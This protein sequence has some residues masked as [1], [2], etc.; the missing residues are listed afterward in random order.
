MKIA[1]ISSI[2][3]TRDMKHLQFDTSHH[4]KSNE[5]IILSVYF[6]GLYVKLFLHL[7]NCNNKRC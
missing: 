2:I 1:N 7:K 4:G 5:F 3:I 6:I